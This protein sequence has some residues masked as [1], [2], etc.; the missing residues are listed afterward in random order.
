[1]PG[2]AVHVPIRMAQEKKKK[3]QKE[4][5]AEARKEEQRVKRR[6]GAITGEFVGE[7]RAPVNLCKVVPGDVS[8]KSVPAR[9]QNPKTD[10][11]LCFQTKSSM[12]E[13][14]TTLEEFLSRAV[15]KETGR[16]SSLPAAGTGLFYSPLAFVK[17]AHEFSLECQTLLRDWKK[18][19][20]HSRELADAALEKDERKRRVTPLDPQSGDADEIGEYGFSGSLPY[21]FEH[22]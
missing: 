14:L 8:F 18:I 11:N 4:N 9:K 17:Q 19:V 7:Y 21:H 2:A 5:E 3:K 6:K 12:S 20:D 16:Y 1:M 22:I 15:E 13:S 10:C